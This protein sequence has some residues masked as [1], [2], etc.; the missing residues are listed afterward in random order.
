MTRWD[1]FRT[2]A[3]GLR[4]IIGGEPPA[5]AGESLPWP[6]IVEVSSRHLVTPALAG[7]FAG[8]S[9]PG[10]VRDYFEAMLDLNRIRNRALLG[11]LDSVLA[12]LNAAGIRPLLMKGA[13]FLAEGCLPDPGIRVTA[14]L[15]LLVREP[16]LPAASDALAAIGFRPGEGFVRT[17]RRH[18]H[19]PALFSESSGARVELHR[20]VSQRRFHGLVNRELSFA[21]AIEVTPGDRAALVASPAE[22]IAHAIVHSQLC[23]RNHRRGVPELRQLLDIAFLR[24]RHDD[25]IDWHA[26]SARFAAAGRLDVLA[27][28]LSCAEVLFGQAMPAGIVFSRAA[29]ERME[30]AVESGGRM[31]IG[32]SLAWFVQDL[33]VALRADPR[34]LL[35]A[36]RGRIQARGG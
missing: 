22:R 2:V 6:D 14:D 9:V 10:E 28:T 5:L 34:R 12:A 15:D 18:H 31:G 20:H 26:L 16:E 11:E 19:L 27:D 21:S 23:D 17:S 30:K 4:P 35:T 32:T 29:I 24:S 25:G 36:V 7:Q 13:A 8:P 3:A 1:I 33:F